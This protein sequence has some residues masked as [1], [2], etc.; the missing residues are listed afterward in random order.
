MQ[1]SPTDELDIELESLEEE[2]AKYLDQAQTDACNSNC[3]YTF[4]SDKMD[5]LYKS[6]AKYAIEEDDKN[7]VV[8]KVIS[9]NF[10]KIKDTK[11][12]HYY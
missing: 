1:S 4:G 2:S 5:E 7:F 11:G 10:Q 12:V 6:H 9:T 3:L 8:E